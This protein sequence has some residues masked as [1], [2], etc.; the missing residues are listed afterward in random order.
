MPVAELEDA[1]R[2]INASIDPLLLV[3]TINYLADKMQVI[4]T[5]LKCFCPL[6]KETAFRSL[7]IDIRKKEYRCTMKMCRGFHGGTLVDLYALHTDQS[8]LQAALSL[9]KLLGIEIDADSFKRIAASYLK[10]AELA[11]NSHRLQEGQ[12]LAS[13]ALEIHP[14]NV[15]AHFLLAQIFDEAGNTTSAAR[16][17]LASVKGY[18]DEEDY[19]RAIETL[20][21]RLLSREPRNEGYLLQLAALYELKDDPETAIATYLRASEER[22]QRGSATANVE[23]YE[24]ILALD[25]ERTEI[26]LKL[27]KLLEQLEQP[28]EAVR[29]YIAVAKSLLE[30]GDQDEALDALQRARKLSPANLEVLRLVADLHLAQQQIDLAEKELLAL[31]QILLTSGDLDGALRAYQTILQHHS[32]SIP[33]LEALVEILVKKNDK[34]AAGQQALNLAK[35]YEDLDEIEK[36]IEFLQVAR[37]CDPASTEIQKHLIKVYLDNK[38][39]EDAFDA[40]LQLAEQ[41]LKEG[42]RREAGEIFAHFTQRFPHEIDKRLLIGRTYE[43]FELREESLEQYRSLATDAQA[44]EDW[45]GALQAS[46]KGLILDPLDDDLTETKVDALLQLQR[47]DAALDWLKSLSR[48]SY[49]TGQAERGEA[50]LKRALAI[51]PDDEDT[52]SLLAEI[53]LSTKRTEQAIAYLKQLLDSRINKAQFDPAIQTC[54][55]I[56]HID[57]EEIDVRMRLATLFVQK[58]EPKNAIEQFSTLADALLEHNRYEDALACLRKI[59]EIDPDSITALRRMA[60]VIA[61]HES[62]EK[63]SPFFLKALEKVKRGGSDKEI[64]KEYQHILSLSEIQYELRREFADFLISV[65]EID[66]ALAELKALAD[67]YR[68][69]LNDYESAARVYQEILQYEP[70]NLDTVLGVADSLRLQSQPEE[71]SR[72]YLLGASKAH[73]LGDEDKAIAIYKQVLEISPDNETARQALGNLLEARGATDQAVKQYQALA[74]IREQ[75]NRTGENIPVYVKLIELDPTLDN[76]REKLAA[77]YESLGETALAANQYLALAKAY[78]DKGDTD[79]VIA[80]L[81]HVKSVEPDNRV[82]R[83]ML[84]EIFI[85]GKQTDR[86]KQEYAELARIFIEKNEFTLAEKFLRSALDLAPKD[87]SLRGDLALL[88]E[89]RGQLDAASQEYASLAQLY[90]DKGEEESAITS[91]ERVKAIQPGKIDARER[92]ATLYESSGHTEEAVREYFDIASIMFERHEH[93]AALALCEHIASLVPDNTQVRIDI[94]ALL[95]TKGYEQEAK[96]ELREAAESAV[97]QHDYA[98]ALN[99]CREGLALD[100]HDTELRETKIRAL[101]GLG[102]IAAATEEYA[103]L[104]ALYFKRKEFDKAEHCYNAILKIRPDDLESH[105]RLVDCYFETGR[106]GEALAK[107]VFIAKTHTSLDQIDDALKAY[108]KVLKT[109]DSLVDVRRDLA[110]LY[111]RSG[112]TDKAL[113]EFDRLANSYHEAKDFPKAIEYL[114]KIL[115]HDPES[116]ETL[117]KLSFTVAESQ[118]VAEARPYFARL[119]DKAKQSAKPKAIL[120]EYEDVLSAD[121][122]NCEIRKDYAEYLRSR[123]KP[124]EAKAQYAALA[125]IYERTPKTHPLAAE[126]LEEIIALFPDDIVTLQRLAVLAESQ[127]DAKTACNYYRRAAEISDSQG[128]SEM[129]I[130]LCEKA[131]RL[132]PQAEEILLTLAGL[133][134]RL[135]QPEK[136]VER[137]LE[138]ATIRSRHNRDPENIDIFHAIL[139]L[140]PG[141]IDVRENLAQL[142]EKEGRLEESVAQLLLIGRERERE[143]RTKP[144]IEAYAHAKRLKPDDT[145]PRDRLIAIYQSIG[146]REKAKQEMDEAGE[147]CLSAGR[148]QEAES[149]FLQMRE[150][151]PTDVANGERLAR[152]YVARHDYE[153]ACREFSNV[154]SAYRARKEPRKALEAL[155]Q[156]KTLKP[157]DLGARKESF[158]IYC[159]LGETESAVKEALDLIVLYFKE[160]K[161]KEAIE[162]SKKIE[163]LAPL[164]VPTRLMIAEQFEKN[165]LLDRALEE[166]F[167]TAYALSEASRFDDALRVC[168]MGL[169][170]NEEHTH[171]HDV[172]VKV[173]LA[174][175]NHPAATEEYK[176]IAAIYSKLGQHAE[177]EKAYQAALKLSPTDIPTIKNLIALYK[178]SGRSA[179]ATDELIHLSGIYQS[180]SKHEEAIEAYRDILQIDPVRLEIREALA[181]TL[182][183]NGRTDDAIGEFFVM[184]ADCEQGNDIRRAISAYQRILEIKPDNID[185]L[186]ALIRLSEQRGD[187]PSLIRYSLLVGSIYEEISAFS[188][189]LEAY[190]RILTIDERN[191]EA[192]H[193]IAAV[194]ELQN[195][196]SDA[197]HIYEKLGNLFVS[198]GED[199]NALSEFEKIRKHAPYDLANLQRLADLYLKQNRHDETISCFTDALAIMRKQADLTP[200]VRVAAKWIAIDPDSTSAHETYAEILEAVNETEE[201]AAEYSRLARIWERQAELNQALETYARLLRIAPSR[202]EDR[203]RYADLLLRTD[204]LGEG[205]EQFLLLSETYQKDKELDKAIACC[206]KIIEKIPE[207]VAAH[208]NLAEIFVA[209]NRKDQALTELQWLADYYLKHANLEDARSCLTRGIELDEHNIPLRETLASLSID[210]GKIEEATEQL[211]KIAEIAIMRGEPDRGIAALEQTKSL[212]AD[213]IEVRRHLA[214]IYWRLDAK[215]RAFDEL[216]QIISI[217][218]EQGLIEEARNLAEDILRRKPESDTWRLRIAEIFEAHQVPELAALYYLEIARLQQQSEAWDALVQFAKKTLFL[219]PYNIQALEL[220]IDGLLR[221]GK[222]TEAYQNYFQLS[223]LY[224]EQ[225]FYHKAADALKTMIEL[226]PDDPEPRKRIIAIYA[227]TKQIDKEVLE[228]RA[229][230]ELYINKNLMEDAVKV[231]KTILDKK[232]EDTRA[233]TKYIDIYSQIGSE[234][235]L[236]SDYLQLIDIY[237]RHGAIVEATKTFERLLKIDPQNTETLDCFITFLLKNGQ[238]TRAI[239]EIQTLASIYNSKGEFKKAINILTQALSLAEDDPELHLKLSESYVQANARGMAIAELRKAA[240]IFE[241]IKQPQQV[242]NVLKRIT[243]LDPQNIDLRVKLIE[244][245]VTLNEISD[246][247]DQSIKLANVYIKRD[248]LDLAEREYRR[249][250]SLDRENTSAWNDLLAIHQQLGFDEEIPKDLLELA[251]LS[252]RNGALEEAIGFLRRAVSLEPE[253]IEYRRKYID[254]YLQYGLEKDLIADYLALAELFVQNKRIDEAQE[255]YNRVQSLAPD[256]DAAREKLEETTRLKKRLEAEVGPEVTAPEAAEAEAAQAAEPIEKESTLEEIAENY[257][258]IL[259]MNPSN[260]SV[261]CKLA[262]IYRRMG[263]ADDAFEQRDTASEILLQ[264]GELDRGIALCEELLKERPTDKRIRERLS[265]AVVRRGSF[266]ALES[267][268]SSYG[269]VI[270]KPETPPEEHENNPPDR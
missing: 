233:R 224:A 96:T 67:A 220:L 157:E 147:I 135:D 199:D 106:Q 95:H 266:K 37:S 236:V 104:A 114:E 198:Q 51:A 258:N 190:K 42:N 69:T 200:A 92:L 38:R 52:L 8:S 54:Q 99:C 116:F 160:R 189:A 151:D 46:E 80:T 122:D 14:E 260:V 142:L 167:K 43:K 254:T 143:S 68:R 10:E 131:L 208:R 21:Q 185:A 109:D 232:P 6:H 108:R 22:E 188:D 256:N 103:A 219:S 269:D 264:K 178:A 239:A 259:Q 98:G 174:T 81:E 34:P 159:E 11:F 249:A 123:N 7:I 79:K 91:L 63:A 18:I 40:T 201:A 245:L 117:R 237:V 228:L 166:Y 134:Q 226:K 26:R 265:K 105:Y 246:A 235:E 144:A 61:Q 44:L 76:T 244:L 217:Y 229:L 230:A 85:K 113:Q 214:E 112:Q 149:Y 182:E 1:I 180:Q 73:E 115:A 12:T 130:T 4:G 93:E 125:D 132:E 127:G 173:F 153:S 207:N 206:E 25:P 212:A 270:D 215:D 20:E 17:F 32:E 31:A 213:N 140:I 243:D 66:M 128:D 165:D 83:E 205:I 261:R 247:T 218:L 101:L 119:I 77:A 120:K 163:K 202:S 194:Y 257:V 75:E 177:E 86:A 242:V 240:D 124:A 175:R 184:A 155:N 16:E 222:R 62:F 267:A 231:Y 33:A 84:I 97:K 88:Y 148:D 268:I 255:L 191:I 107:L 251:D 170:L 58:G 35:I 59:I 56:L 146:E 64:I 225:G 171:L 197:T 136:A 70:D 102:D 168:D 195:N 138:I 72:Y 53:T 19:D 221:T 238:N 141:R 118:G 89:K 193:R 139:E 121:P 181:E 204:H 152:L 15:K 234:L 65:G 210:Q 164:D 186:R 150:L 133:H 45:E 156:I 30:A 36:T 28:D 209:Q 227:R 2:H 100:E 129:A 39:V 241:S 60:N 49:E 24:K 161:P 47:A 158:T 216:L 262:D 154:S 23:I 71:A 13:Q 27:A 169:N 110:D 172:K 50:T 5:T 74:A 192:L 137:Y 253:N 126:A 223:D 179:A 252:V 9:A 29:E 78:R 183:S 55:Q 263:R 248:L 196:Y 41:C 82:P 162:L 87:L 3:K 94:A 176:T 187:S 145:E 111:L 90:E 48:N 211:L 203:E 57:P 250:L